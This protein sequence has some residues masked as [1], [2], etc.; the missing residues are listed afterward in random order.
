MNSFS[1]ASFERFKKK[2]NSKQVSIEMISVKNCTIKLELRIINLHLHNYEIH[3]IH[4]QLFTTIS[5]DDE[6]FKK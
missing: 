4:S 3:I 1:N 2:K 6:Y 5:N